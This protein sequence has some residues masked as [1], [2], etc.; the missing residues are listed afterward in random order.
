[1][2]TRLDSVHRFNV[3]E[4]H[5]MRDLG[6]LPERGVE[7]IEG[8]IVLAGGRP[9]RFDVDDYHWLAEAGILAEDDRVELIN[10]EIID[11]TP[12]GSRHAACVS[13]LTRLLVARV[14]DAIVR[15]QDPLRVWGP[16]E[17][18]PDLTVVRFREDFY[19]EQHPAPGDVLLV[20][21]VADSSLVRDRTEKAEMYATVGIREYWLVDLTGSNVMVHSDPSG[22]GY[23]SVETRQRDDSWTSYSLPGL[24]VSGVEI[25]G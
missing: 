15:V 1:M 11:M 17:P 20:I 16:T 8:R 7:L 23:L 5:R 12:A 2:A 6:I 14:G 18:E 4:Y 13:R 25:L 24:T 22:A 21:E 3:D 19:V 9:W 10:G